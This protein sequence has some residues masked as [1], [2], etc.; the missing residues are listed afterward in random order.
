MRRIFLIT[1]L[2]GI[3]GVTL[4]LYNVEHLEKLFE[5]NLPVQSEQAKETAPSSSFFSIKKNDSY[6]KFSV[7]GGEDLEALNDSVGET[8]SKADYK[9][10]PKHKRSS[11]RYT[12]KPTK[13]FPEKTP[14]NQKAWSSV[15]YYDG[16]VK[17]NNRT[18]EL[19]VNRTGIGF[20]RCRAKTCG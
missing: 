20:N 1:F 3:T 11:N 14:T 4:G 10:Y 9:P 13:K 2:A 19:Q 7:D 12:A 6:A 16:G 18:R 8:F 5:S 15:R 17:K